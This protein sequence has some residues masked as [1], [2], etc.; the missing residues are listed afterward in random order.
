M[1]PV[2]KRRTTGRLPDR[3]GSGTLAAK[4]GRAMS[5]KL[6]IICAAAA[7][8]ALLAFGAPVSAK[9]AKCVIKTNDGSYA[10]ACTFS[11]S[12]GGSFS[13]GP[14]GRPDFF[15]HAPGEPGVTTIS[16]DIEG[17]NAEVHGLTTDGVNSRWGPATRSKRD[18]A[19]WV[20]EDFSVCLY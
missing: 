1:F 2:R 17:E 15:D 11:R 3:A 8:M 10:A 19:C 6:P 18:P 20:G 12:P 13:I 5:G 16:V 14:V 4:E 9:D 7:G